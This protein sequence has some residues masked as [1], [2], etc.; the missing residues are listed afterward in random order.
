MRIIK[1]VRVADARI[2]GI[3]ALALI[4]LG[5]RLVTADK[6]QLQALIAEIDGVLQKTTP[7][8]PWV[9]SGDANQQRK[10]LE[11]VRNHLV[12]WQ[13]RMDLEA[14]D[15][16]APG[17]RA[18]A[19]GRAGEPPMDSRAE[20]VTY[21]IYYQPSQPQLSQSPD[22]P[23]GQAAFSTQQMLQ[24]MM[25]EMVQMRTSVMQPLQSELATLRQQR[26][27]LQSEVRQLETQKQTALSQQQTTQQQL[28]EMLQAW[29]GRV[30]DG[31]SLQINQSFQNLS[32]PALAAAANPA[33]LGS[34]A[35][36]GAMPLAGSTV[37]GDVPPAE[38][39]LANLD[40]SL[41]L[42]F[43]A[44]QRDVQ[45]YQE[46]LNQGLGR[47]HGLG[48]QSEMM[49]TALLGHLAQQVG[50]EASTYLQPGL[51]ASELPAGLP[52]APLPDIATAVVSPSSG[53]VGS[54]NQSFPYPGTEVGPTMRGAAIANPTVANPTVANP[55]VVDATVT[56]VSPVV[57]DSAPNS[58]TDIDMAIDDWIRAT[59]SADADPPL[60]AEFADLNLAAFS[61]SQLDAQEIDLL[62][63]AAM[64]PD[65]IG[66][67]TDNSAEIDDS[68]GFLGD[69]GLDS[70]DLDSADLGSANIGNAS[71]ATAIADNT[72]PTTGDRADTLDT[73]YHSLFGSAGTEAASVPGPAAPNPVVP[74][75]SPPAPPE[76][77]HSLADLFGD[78]PDLGTAPS[79]DPASSDQFILAAPEETLLPPA[80]GELERASGLQLDAMT[81]SSLS[82]DLSN[83]ERSGLSSPAAATP[84]AATPV[85]PPPTAQT[86]EEPFSLDF[87]LE[88]LAAI[89]QPASPVAIQDDVSLDDFA[90]TMGATASGAP[91]SGAPT[92]DVAGAPPVGSA[93]PPPAIASRRAVPPPP[94]P[95]GRASSPPLRSSGRMTLE[96]M[97]SLF[98]DAPGLSIA[99]AAA[100]PNPPIVSVPAPAPSTANPENRFTIDDMA[101]LFPNAQAVAPVTP[102]PTTIPPQSADPGMNQ[103]LASPAVA[104]DA[105]SADLTLGGLDDLFSGVPA[106]Q[107]GAERGVNANPADFT[108]D[109]IGNLFIEAPASS[110]STASREIF[111]EADFNTDLFND[112]N[113]TFN[114]NS[115]Q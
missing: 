75:P 18:A 91:T 113:T 85:A 65:A 105:D 100:P 42:V 90:Q 50:R 62:G 44:L 31:L 34:A 57:P 56:D 46:S 64:S 19:G 17:V 112:F 49:V 3:P 107:T 67:M 86:L 71:G 52:M 96:D 77:I 27:T 73:F 43:D 104:Q 87:S 14:G 21:D 16:F 8:L 97:N 66:F 2:A 109:Q 55:T 69:A 74:P 9:M 22:P 61:F 58:V 93:T 63:T 20:L 80:P 48:Q 89:P 94:P 47:L 53:D 1:Q 68:L 84:A 7:R 38:Q 111:D 115:A 12:A 82:E 92:S 60:P 13:R 33:L 54:E 37:V 24:Q 106:P 30:Q 10:V 36:G 35:S 81:F 41:R 70:A 5:V 32:H 108:V 83:L 28:N 79:S 102:V 88:A 51:Q 45:S 6:E 101:D 103:D 11:R 29:L 78:L 76:Q 99:P 114:P 26:E 4:T 72:V 23:H 25:Q 98:D 59:G 15:R 110:S 39:L 95:F 40:A